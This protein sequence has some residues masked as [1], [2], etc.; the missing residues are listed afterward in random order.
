[1]SS[2]APALSV[3]CKNPVEQF[4]G[5]RFE[6]RAA[7]LFRPRNR[8]DQRR[9]IERIDLM[10]LTIGT[11]NP[12][13]ISAGAI[14]PRRSMTTSMS[15]RLEAGRIASTNKSISAGSRGNSRYVSSPC[16]LSTQHS[17]RAR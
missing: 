15:L 12:L 1:M 8:P 7:G 11:I 13:Q 9:P 16:M 4:L 14:G 10:D 5:R 3:S 17:W 2:V 6:P